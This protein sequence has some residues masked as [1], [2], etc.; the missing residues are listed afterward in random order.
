MTSKRKI[1]SLKALLA[2]ACAVLLLTACSSGSIS[3]LSELKEPGR[4]IGVSFETPEADFAEQE[5]PEAEIVTYLDMR[6]AYDDVANGKIDACLYARR[7]MEL[8]I[9]KGLKGVKLLD[10]SFCQDLVAVGISRQS[11]I[12]ELKEKINQFL[13]EMRE[14]GTLDDM[15]ERWV[16]KVDENMPEIEM[17]ENPVYHLCVATTGNVFPYSYYRDK[18]LNGYDIELAMRFA[19][20]LDADLEFLIYDFD[21]IIQVTA[22]GEADCAMSDLFYTPQHAEVIDYS[23]VLFEV[24]VTAMVKE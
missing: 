14:N 4:K 23:D 13:K 3:S 21:L 17:P 7:E 5:Y 24:D 12:P 10:E 1:K 15:Y 19:S 22:S 9:E 18:E 2:V 20:W 16:V 8:A 6:P 11:S